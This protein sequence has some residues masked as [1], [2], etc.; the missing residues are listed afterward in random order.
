MKIN[1]AELKETD[2]IPKVDFNLASKIFSIWL[3]D[4][5]ITSVFKNLKTLLQKGACSENR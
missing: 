4:D 3:L 5:F 1:S 2:E